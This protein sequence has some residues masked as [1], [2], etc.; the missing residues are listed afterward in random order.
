[1]FLQIPGNGSRN[2]ED[3]TAEQHD[4]EEWMKWG[5]SL[6]RPLDTVPALATGANPVTIGAKGYTEWRTVPAA[7]TLTVGTGSAWYLYDAGFGVLDGGT[8]FPATVSAPAGS[9]LALFGPAG[10]VTTVTV[11]PAA[12]TSPS[13]AAPRATPRRIAPRDLMQL[14]LALFGPAGSST[15]LAVATD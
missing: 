2:L 15:T 1:M 8:T 4:G 14:R 3:L 11:A 10:S 6:F 13:P 5:N 9:H 12:G 7:V